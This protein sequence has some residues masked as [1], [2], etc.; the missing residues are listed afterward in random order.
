MRIGSRAE[1]RI[2]AGGVCAAALALSGCA[3]QAPAPDDR[4][5]KVEL[6]GS[7]RVPAPT[8]DRMLLWGDTHLHT[9]N[10][11]DAF[12]SGNATD[13]DTA[14]RFAKGYPV[15][16]PR[17]Q[18]RVRIDRPLDFLVVSD[19]AVNL[20]INSRIQDNDPRLLKLPIGKRLRQLYE[21]SG[22]RALTTSAMGG[23]N[24]T[25]QER[26]EYADTFHTDEVLHD[27]WQ[28]QIDAAERYN[29]PGKFTALIGWEWTS[30]P[31]LRN[32]H[33]VVFTNVGGD[34]ATKFSPF[35]N[36]MSERPEDLWNFLEQTR[37]RTGADFIAM[38]HNANL[39]DGR[40]FELT[41]SDGNP[42]TADYARK[43]QAWEPVTEVTQY[44]GTS[45]THPELS[46]TDEFAGYELRNMLLTGVPT[47]VSAGSYVRGALL[48]GLA[49][50]QR[51]GVNPF[52]YG[53]GG[54]TD[55]HTGLVSVDEKNFLGKLAE[56]YLP[57]DRLGPD[58]VP[59]IFPA[60]EMSAAG[61]TGAWADE[62]T[63]QGVFDA[64]RRREVYAT[65]GPRMR[66]RLFAGYGF[67]AGDEKAADF[68]TIGYRK[69]VPM[70][71]QLAPSTGVAPRFVIRAEK[72]PMNAGL[73]RVQV[74]KGWV[75]SAGKTH[76]KV[77]DV[78]W[79]GDR[80]IGANGKLPAVADPV[81]KVHWRNDWN[82]GA[83]E[84]AT[85][86]SDP[87]FDPKQRAFY[88]VRVLQVP[89]IRHHVYDALALNID[90]ATLKLPTTIQERAW[91]SPVWYTP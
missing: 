83:S 55:S 41:D 69:G 52:R 88:Y 74:I 22:A 2:L 32:L 76:E 70:G 42:F 79:S 65:S 4:P 17:T 39:S 7:T 90:P 86:W 3:Q 44:K 54:A 59:I 28:G 29:E 61:L 84:L 21:A 31:A 18:Q 82:A 23:S 60:A 80:R 66:V 87:E 71:G 73:D 40:M 77:F 13:I 8:Q 19:H 51:I 35:A 68:G 14:Y 56:D 37:D 57:K 48:R 62:N 50:E 33:R 30:A 6:A 38:P 89:T 64:F 53:M 43:R 5:L 72:D 16:F 47:E 11:V 81:D 46:S 85:F 26:K 34:V 24:L 49:E 75:D 67:A 45:E 91:S 9:R 20:S 58:K 1:L 10:S 36:W 27:S 15:V 78:V 12:G 25:P 63:R